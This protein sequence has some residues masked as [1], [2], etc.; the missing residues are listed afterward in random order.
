MKG[1]GCRYLLE[2]MHS[3]GKVFS[4]PSCVRA[5]EAGAEGGL[6][7]EKRDTDRETGPKKQEDK[8][9]ARKPG[10]DSKL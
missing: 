5:C 1:S 3:L 6:K 2:K 7:M 9:E 10:C 8:E 4:K